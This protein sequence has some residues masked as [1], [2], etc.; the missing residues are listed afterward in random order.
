[1]NPEA[2]KIEQGAAHVTSDAAAAAASPGYDPT[3][4]LLAAEQHGKATKRKLM[5]DRLKSLRER[6]QISE[7]EAKAGWEIRLILE[8]Q[9]GGHDPFAR[10]QFSER[11]A[12]STNAD[13]LWQTLSEAEGKHFARWKAWALDFPATSAASLY[14]LTVMIAVE[15][16]PITLA[17]ATLRTEYYRA[18]RLLRR[19][20]AMY[21]HMAG[22]SPTAEPPEIK[23]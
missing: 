16:M 13:V 11:L 21:A 22:W 6:R 2:R 1:M 12:A 15:E 5:C 17:V 4:A 19:S 14:R 3:A 20:L 7:I 10:S 18:R 23:S 8:W 9:A